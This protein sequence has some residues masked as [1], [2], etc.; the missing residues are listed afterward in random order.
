MVVKRKCGLQYKTEQV[1][2]THAK[3]INRKEKKKPERRK[4][5]QSKVV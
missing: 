1:I 5:E 4:T 2:K 3:N